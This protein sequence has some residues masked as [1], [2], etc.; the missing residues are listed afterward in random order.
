MAA[1]DRKLIDRVIS[2]GQNGQAMGRYHPWGTEST[3]AYHPLVHV[4]INAG[5]ISVAQGEP[6]YAGGP[7]R[8]P[9]AATAPGHWQQLYAAGRP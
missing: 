8:T 6:L 9:I 7:T 5:G 1:D 3:P 2:Q 4:Q